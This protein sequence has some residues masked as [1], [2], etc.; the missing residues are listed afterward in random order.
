MEFQNHVFFVWMQ[1]DQNCKVQMRNKIVKPE[2][3]MKMNFVKKGD[4]LA[5]LWPISICSKIESQMP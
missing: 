2:A 4:F 5:K 1:W 3:R